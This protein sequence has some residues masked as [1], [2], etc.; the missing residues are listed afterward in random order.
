MN[1][2]ISSFFTMRH[3]ATLQPRVPLPSNKHFWDLIMSK[4]IV[5][6][7]RHFMSFKFKLTADSAN[8]SVFILS[9]MSTTFGWSKFFSFLSQPIIV[10]STWAPSQDTSFNSMVNTILLA[11]LRFPFLYWSLNDKT[12][13]VL[14]LSVFSVLEFLLFFKFDAKNLIK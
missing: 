8:F 9:A 12:S 13:T 6:A 4:L 14:V 1:R 11:I 7:I 10:L 3:L 2:L 5:G